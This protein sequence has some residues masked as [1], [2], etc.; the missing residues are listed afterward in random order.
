M[1]LLLLFKDSVRVFL[2]ELVHI[3]VCAMCIGIVLSCDRPFLILLE[4]VQARGVR[5]LSWVEK[6]F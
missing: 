2:G 4:L 5:G 3:S 1:F 6:I